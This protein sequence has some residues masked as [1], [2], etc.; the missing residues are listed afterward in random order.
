ML[1][2]KKF[3]VVDPG[4]RDLMTMMNEEG[5]FLRYSNR[6]RIK[7]TKRLKYGRLIKNHKDNLG[8]TEIEEELAGENS[9][10]CNLDVFTRFIKKKNEL[11][12]KL[13][14]LYQ[15]E[16]FRKIHWFSFIETKR[17]EVKMLDL[18]EETYGKDINIIHGD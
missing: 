11:N 13:L 2:N 1:K 12:I 10:S 8:I 9:K 3:V 7:E 15:D 18:I 4:K 17:S 16:K 5:K 6:K 14:K